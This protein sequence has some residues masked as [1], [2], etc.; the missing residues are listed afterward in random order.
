M[1][2]QSETTLSEQILSRAAGRPVRAGEL[3]TLR[4]DR[5][6]LHDSI[7]PSVIRILAE[8]L[9]VERLPEPD[10]VAVVIDHVAPA[11][12]VQTAIKQRELRRWVESQGI[13]RFFESGRG[14]CHQVLIEEHLVGPGDVV[15]GTDSHSTTYGAVGAFGTGMG[16]TDVAVCLASGRTWMRVPEA[17]RIDVRGRFAGGTGPKD[18]ALEIVRR[19]SARGGTYAALEVFGLDEHL[20]GSRMTV[21]SMAI[22]AG[23]KAGLVWPGGLEDAGFAAP[24]WLREPA[25]EA[26]YARRI[27]IDL[28]DLR[29]SVARPGRVDDVV[30][31][32]ELTAELGEVPVDVVYVGTCTNGRLDDLRTVARALAGRRVARGV[33]LMVVP[34]SSQVLAEAVADGTVST[35]LAAGA[36]LGPPGC[37]ACIGRHLGV[38]AP[39]ETCVFTGNRNFSGRM[40]SP[41]ARIFLASPEVAAASA[42]AGRLAAPSRRPAPG[43]SAPAL[44][45]L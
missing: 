38:L 27:E 8:D 11:A 19:L 18:L 40:G 33:R 20:L 42:L 35:L 44:S 10:R 29:H 15:V 23:A 30:P 1:T 17:I 28:A 16:S 14:I 13:E 36:T 39:G 22:E 45:S 37:G 3:V 32:D 6:M 43:A 2:T 9:G 41:D 24:G 34:A 25:R 21:A 5:V 4:P 31:I 26:G 7:G 12:S